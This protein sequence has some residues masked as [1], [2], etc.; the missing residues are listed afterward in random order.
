M[1]HDLYIEQIQWQRYQAPLLNSFKL[2]E[3]IGTLEDYSEIS[4]DSKDTAID[5]ADGVAVYGRL[6][7]RGGKS[8]TMSTSVNIR[9]D[10]GVKHVL[11]IRQSLQNILF[12][13]IWWMTCFIRR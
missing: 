7:D 2:E 3:N 8:R 10:L 5:I 12:S 1:V 13:G 9:H 4:E 11:K 6:S